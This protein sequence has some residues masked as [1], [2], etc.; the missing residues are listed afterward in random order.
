MKQTVQ[1][2]AGACLISILVASC[3][4]AAAPET[5]TNT[6]GAAAPPVIEP[7]IPLD[8]SKPTGSINRSPPSQDRP[9]SQQ[10][11][12]P[13]ETRESRPARTQIPITVRAAGTT[14][15]QPTPV[16]DKTQ[17]RQDAA[18]GTNENQPTPVA[19][20]TRNREDAAIRPTRART[21]PPSRESTDTTEPT[22]ARRADSQDDWFINSLTE[23]DRTCLPDSVRKN[24]NVTQYLE[25]F[26][27]VGEYE[28]RT[29][30]SEQG[31]FALYLLD[32]PSSELEHDEE[33][34]VWRGLRGA[35]RVPGPTATVGTITEQHYLAEQATR[36]AEIAV[37]AYC[38]QDGDK[39]PA[40]TRD[41]DDETRRILICL[42]ELMGGPDRFMSANL[43]RNTVA[44]ELEQAI[45]GQGP[46]AAPS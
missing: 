21:T 14:D 45:A 6:I 1:S 15:N 29:C 39:A 9:P 43:Q 16:A 41:Q 22:W 3:T 32:R 23:Q 17:N 7:L 31:Q 18:V 20:N 24:R 34:C 38:T 30:L 5:A 42:V 12:T 4:P 11:I 25:L 46:C 44:A 40:A 13:P 19:D 10:Q 28:L 2:L 33:V 8:A 36:D 37:I 27:E 35:N 26:G